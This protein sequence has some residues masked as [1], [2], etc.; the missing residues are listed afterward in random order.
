MFIRTS[1]ESTVVLFNTT[2]KVSAA[3]SVPHNQARHVIRIKLHTN[4]HSVIFSSR[5]TVDPG[6]ILGTVGVRWEYTLDRIPVSQL[7]IYH[8][9]HSDIHTLIHNGGQFRVTNPLT[10][11]FW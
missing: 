9:G 2:L 5:D 7:A 3:V 4:I 1:Y 10:G 8:I 11:I 6:P